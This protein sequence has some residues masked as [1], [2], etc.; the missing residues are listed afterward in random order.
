MTKKFEVAIVGGG[1]AGATCAYELAKAGINVAIFDHSHPREKPC[2]GGLPK[3]FFNDF[4]LP[5]GVKKRIINWIIVE[6]QNGHKV[7]LYQKFGGVTMMRKEFDHALFKKTKK[8]GTFCID[9]RVIEVG[10]K[11]GKWVVK[12]KG[13]EYEA[14]FLVG[15][16]GCL[17]IV[18]NY[19]LGGIG[20]KYLAHAVG[21]HIPHSKS[22]MKK[23]FEDAIEFYFLGKPYLKKGYIWIF[24]K[25]DF[26]TV[27]LMTNLGTSEI[28][29][30]LEKFIKTH[31]AAKKI[32][33]PDKI[34][35]HSH[36]IP[37][38]NSTKFY[39]LPTSG[40]NWVLIGDAAGHV[41]PIT[42]EGIYYAMMGGK[43]AA[44]AYLENDITKYETY[45]RKKFGPDLYWGSR[46]Q[47]IFY[48]MRLLGI[49]LK[50]AK[51]SPTMR[52]ILADIIAVREP[53]GD[54]LNV[55]PKFIKSLFEAII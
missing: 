40:E 8:A 20:K 43:L 54:I 22:D 45:W 26:V 4:D 14:D 49:I 1:P 47:S 7:K 37:F 16:D 46:M 12:T 44:K 18:R 13:K 15:A 23:K 19:V 50:I 55:V 29:G 24:P 17:S 27:G 11:N 30:S 21:Y 41:N 34:S 28:R 36:L 32:L 42:G 5:K 38:V 10:Y 53:Y 51:R 52:E 35:I 9:K 25:L 33:L 6:D 48:D 2:G 31:H 3:R 39:D